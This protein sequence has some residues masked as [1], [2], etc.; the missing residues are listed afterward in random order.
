MKILVVGAGIAGLAIGWRLAQAG[1]TV[2]IVER[3][4]PGRAA[5]WAAAGM[6]APGAELSTD[7]DALS[8]FA[9]AARAAWPAFARELEGASGWDIG[10]S[11]I[12]SL[13]VAQTEAR[14]ASLKRHAAGEWLTREKWLARE[15]LLSPHLHGALYVP[16]DAQVDNRVLG[17]ALSAALARLSVPLRH[18]L[19]AR[20]LIVDGGRVR[21]IVTPSGSLFGDAVI[22][23]C[24]AWM[25][26]LE[27][28]RADELPPVRPA[29][30]QM[31]ALAPPDGVALPHCLIWDDEVYLAPRRDRIFIGATV[32]DA[33]FDT[34]VTREACRRLVAEAAWIIPA[35]AQWRIAEMW[36]GLRPRTPDSAPVL[37]ESGIAGLYVAGGQ[38]RNGILFAP[39]VAAAISA[40]VLGREN[41]AEIRAFDPRRFNALA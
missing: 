36:A 8:H 39:A 21:G 37:G 18:N 29:K 31:V 16:D 35:L 2:E 34:S 17:D 10:F 13:I 4:L 26:L 20:A 33:G 14:A 15:P 12:G 24:G 5:S 3:G 41:N 27:G 1:A 25:N 6:L 7:D 23:A 9:R 40:L 11:V 30:G 32:E 22:L 28:I 38:F 19:A